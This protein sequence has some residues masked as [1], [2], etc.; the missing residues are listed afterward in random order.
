M[1]SRVKLRINP[2]IHW[3]L[4]LFLFVSIVSKKNQRLLIYIKNLQEMNEK[5]LLNIITYVVNL[6][7]CVV[8]HKNRITSML[9]RVKKILVTGLLEMKNNN[10]RIWEDMTR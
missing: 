10:V 1:F 2:D 8:K 9:K 3:L 5:L 4:N 7:F 6:Y